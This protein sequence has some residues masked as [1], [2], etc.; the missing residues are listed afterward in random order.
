MTTNHRLS[1]RARLRAWLAT[2]IAHRISLA[3][4]G[5]GGAF[6]LVI[7]L[8]SFAITQALVRDSVQ[9]EMASEATL[10][11]ERLAL[12]LRGISQGLERL[13]Q[14]SLV[15]NALVDSSGRSGYL[16]PYLREY[17]LADNIPF[18]L[19]LTDHA[20][21]TIAASQP[22]AT[23]AKSAAWIRAQVDK[24]QPHAEILGNEP[25]RL[26]LAYPVIFPTTNTPEGLMMMEV[27][28][29][30]LL[31]Q[32][33]DGEG[34]SHLELRTSDRRIGAR[35]PSGIDRPVT[36]DRPL[37]MLPPL[38]QLG[39]RITAARPWLSAY[40]SLLIVGLAYL[41]IAAGALLL[42][43]R[44]ARLA[45]KRLV[46]PLHQLATVADHN[47]AE[48]ETK[49]DFPITGTDEVG[50]LARALQEMVEQL[51]AEH[52]LLEQRVAER[53]A[54]L[55]D[56]T[57]IVR[58]TSNGVVITDPQGRVEWVNEGFVRLSGYAL[59]EL[60][61][62]KPGSV[63][64]GPDS[65]PATIRYM[66]QQFGAGQGFAV[67]IVNYR[68]DGTAYWVGIDA[69]PIR[70]EQ[71]RI[72]KF[73][74]LET[75]ITERKRVDQLKTDFV[76][77][78]SHELRTPLTAI[79][80]ALGLLTG[81]VT[82]PLSAA[83]HELATRAL[84]NSE[85]LTRLIND[86]LDIQK[87][88][89]GKMRFDLTDCPLPRLLQEAL[90]ANQAYALRYKVPLELIEPVAPVSVRVDEGRF[91]QVMANLLSN[92]AKFSPEGQTVSVSAEVLPT[93]R[94]R[95]GVRDRGCGIAPEFRDRIFQKFSQAD[96]STTR[97]RDGTGLGL[98]IT[99]V[100]VEGMGGQIGF[101]TAAG[102]GT[103]FYVELPLAETP[104]ELTS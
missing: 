44:L 40:R 82:G 34:R 98:S 74:A 41:G 50:Q 51:R 48:R 31:R 73:V 56:L 15:S 61:G 28:L 100:L 14:S 97:A 26:L 23:P 104:P 95:I 53:T 37:A 32:T 94:T 71:G 13:A 18:T 63:L 80:G 8:L 17:R 76:S 5:L 42:L 47:R 87:I 59:D 10:A 57:Y 35:A 77:V 2:S 89:S 24:N 75:D 12:E 7:A 92:A 4:A 64:Q 30:S 91:Q 88:E 72:E 38:Q 27:A 16:E 84:A 36:V 70:D 93:G 69:Q 58:R 29:P 65:D 81:G 46:A 66:T 11:A 60:R 52:A 62:R 99:K 86:L 6:V 103:T 78:V 19:L 101:D 67:E 90:L 9:A 85:R 1:L 22:G 102:Q 20:G 33:L 54:E 43:V 79:R 68:K 45:A 21:Q 3:A 39:L 49:A 55:N 83:G 96:A 25:P